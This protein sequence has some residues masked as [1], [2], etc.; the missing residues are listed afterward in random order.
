[1]PPFQSPLS[2]VVNGV[3]VGPAT[4]PILVGSEILQESVNISDF[5]YVFFV[6]IYVVPSLVLYY[7]P[8]PLFPRPSTFLC[9]SSNPPYVIPL[10]WS[11]AYRPS[12]SYCLRISVFHNSLSLTLSTSPSL[13]VLR[14]NHKNPFILWHRTFSSLLLHAYIPLTCERFTLHVI[15][16]DFQD[17]SPR[18]RLGGIYTRQTNI[19]RPE[20]PE[21]SGLSWER[22]ARAEKYTKLCDTHTIQINFD[23]THSRHYGTRETRGAPTSEECCKKAVSK[24]NA[25]VAL[26]TWGTHNREE[27][28]APILNQRFVN[29]VEFGRGTGGI[30]TPGRPCLTGLYEHENSAR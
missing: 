10:T 26:R 13:V 27:W 25:S 3:M 21:G 29:D 14:A 6:T 8:L 4:L 23:R 2:L 9:A 19:S 30:L 18:K 5:L 22:S 15:F 28:V 12:R 20:G 24:M 11:F 1:M 7:T 16:T 17:N